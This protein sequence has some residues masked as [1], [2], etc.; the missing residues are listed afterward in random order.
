MVEELRTHIGQKKKNRLPQVLNKLC[1]YIDFGLPFYLHLNY[2]SKVKAG[3]VFLSLN[4]CDKLNYHLNCKRKKRL[5]P[6]F[7]FS[8]GY[9]LKLLFLHDTCLV[10][11]V[12]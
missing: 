6:L 9:T 2:F 12:D 1:E 11:R 7:P 3:K 4:R 5:N 10:L 8:L